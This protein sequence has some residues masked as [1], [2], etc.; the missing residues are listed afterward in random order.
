MALINI[1]VGF[2]FSNVKANKN[3]ACL[4]IDKFF[5]KFFKWHFVI[6]GQVK[7]IK[8]FFLIT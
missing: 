7:R 6:Y 3:K 1:K 2:S 4:T 5:I 8:Y